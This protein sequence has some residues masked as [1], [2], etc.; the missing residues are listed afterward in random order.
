MH[1]HRPSKI[2]IALRYYYSSEPARG[3]ELAN[4]SDMHEL[5]DD[6]ILERS[7][8]GFTLSQR[9]QLWIELVTRTPYPQLRYIDPRNNRVIADDTLAEQTQDDASP[10]LAALTVNS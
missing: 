10:T 7:G 4:A 8:R 6:G 1:R 9:G 3:L 5:V 2:E